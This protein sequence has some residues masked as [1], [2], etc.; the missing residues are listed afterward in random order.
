MPPTG[1]RARCD[2]CGWLGRPQATL[3]A[4]LKAAKGHI[5]LPVAGGVAFPVS[6]WTGIPWVPP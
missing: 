1:F 3:P 6:E 5:C 2:K 4:A